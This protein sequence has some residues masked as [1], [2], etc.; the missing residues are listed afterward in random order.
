MP[1]L[2]LAS[3][4][5]GRHSG[6]Q[7]PDGDILIFAGD[8]MTCGYK[9]S[10]VY[11]F[12]DW[13]DALPHSQKILIAGNHDRFVQDYPS[14][15]LHEHLAIQ[16]PDLKYLQDSSARVAG[17]KIY[18]S[19]WQPDFCNWA[20]NL[21]RGKALKA[22]WDLIQPNTDVLVTHGPPR[23]ILDNCP[24]YRSVGDDDLLDATL[25]VKPKLHV[26]GHIHNDYGQKQIGDTL[27]VNASI[28][29]EDYE[30]VNAPIVV[31]L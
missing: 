18:G 25:R 16:H 28:C 8:F 4:T 9:E 24:G 27:F 11:D 12:L 21:P 6:V 13:L 10:E 26:F 30:P 17:L 3:D 23:G 1:R 7:V 31:D 19:P 22:K 5:H 14:T 20:F 29:N 2:V 15:V